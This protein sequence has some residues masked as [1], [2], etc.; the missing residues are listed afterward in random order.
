MAGHAASFTV[1][2]DR[3][4]KPDGCLALV[5]PVT[6]LA[7]ESWRQ[8]RAMLAERYEIELVVSSHDS[9]LR[10]MS[11][12]THIAEVLLVARRLRAGERPP[13]RGG[14][15]NLCQTP[16][17]E[18]DAL[19]LANAI[20]AATEFPLHRSDGPRLARVGCSWAASSGANCRT[21]LWTMVRGLLPAGD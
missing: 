2:G 5:L 6:A 8:V 16:R 4:V 7:G 14:F 12:D 15:V 19:A 18:T 11:Y 9:E 10:S 21:D 3:L 1:P 20:S 17:R 13:G